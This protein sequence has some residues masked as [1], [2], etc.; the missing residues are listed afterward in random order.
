[1]KKK[2]LTQRQKVAAWKKKLDKT[3]PPETLIQLLSGIPSPENLLGV[4]RVTLSRWKTGKSRIPLAAVR[5]LQLLHGELPKCFGEWQGWRF[6]QA[7]E[8]FPPGWG[9]G[10]HR[11]DIVDLWTWRR[12]AFMAGAL[13]AENI[14]L[15]RDLAFYRNEILKQKRLGFAQA[16]VDVLTD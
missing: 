14:R 6:S 2:T 5:L 12:R 13:E 4:D 9:E 7:G 16:L 3:T 11:A 10:I 15:K 1:M 8:L